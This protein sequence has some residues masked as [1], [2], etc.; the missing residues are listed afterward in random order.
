MFEYLSFFFQQNNFIS[1]DAEDMLKNPDQ[2]ILK[3]ENGQPV[4]I[5]FKFDN[6]CIRFMGVKLKLTVFVK[7][8]LV[9]V[10]NSFWPPP[11]RYHAVQGEFVP[12]LVRQEVN[13]HCSV[14]SPLFSD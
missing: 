4:F 8:A 10:Q 2:S 12:L 13:A 14:I 1:I 3:I 6:I 11:F 9:G 5:L 7:N